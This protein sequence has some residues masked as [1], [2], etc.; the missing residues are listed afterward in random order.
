[1]HDVLDDRDLVPDE[2]EQLVTSGYPAGPLLARARAAAQ[3]SDRPR[4]A[5]IEAE[6]AALP[7]DP[8]WPYREPG[9]DELPALL[10]A[11]WPPWAAGRGSRAGWSWAGRSWPTAC[12]GPGWAG[13][14]ATRWASR[15]R[16]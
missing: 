3:A 6:L 4:L 7:R 5:E 15:S 16:A 8:G 12:T 10:P 2:A 9:A 1:M 11:P 14:W 13:A